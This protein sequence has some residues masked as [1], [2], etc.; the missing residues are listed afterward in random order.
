MFAVF[1]D[2]LNRRTGGVLM[3]KGKLKGT[4]GKGMM[5]GLRIWGLKLHMSDIQWVFE[6]ME[7]SVVRVLRGKGKCLCQ[8]DF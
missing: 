6:L 8:Y 2:S 4:R 7:P 1:S 3:T 5:N